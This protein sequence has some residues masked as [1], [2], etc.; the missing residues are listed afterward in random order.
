M[1]P[2]SVYDEM[3]DFEK[4]CNNRAT[5]LN[6]YLVLYETTNEKGEPV[7]KKTAMMCPS[8]TH[9]VIRFPTCVKLELLS[10]GYVSI[11]PIISPKLGEET[12][13]DPEEV[14][15]PV[16]VVQQPPPR[17][18]PVPAHE[19]PAPAQ[20]A[21]DAQR[22]VPFIAGLG[23]CRVCK[24]S[25]FALGNTEHRCSANPKGHRF[26]KDPATKRCE[27]FEFP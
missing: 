15:A 24:H 14:P 19:T 3:L 1:P 10:D 22:R 4:R 8:A 23:L 26:D 25:P 7:V 27:R 5:S 6:T 2:Q 21:P 12:D 18:K 16:P 20:T 13:A 11:A 9:V 17:P